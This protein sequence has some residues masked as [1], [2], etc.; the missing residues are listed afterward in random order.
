MAVDPNISLD[1]TGGGTG[2]S[3]PGQVPQ[4]NPLQTVGNIA[5]VQS[6][7]NAVR[8]FQAEMAAKQ[9]AGQILSAA[10]DLDTGIAALQRDPQTAAFAPQIA[11]SAA[12]T[13]ATMIAAAGQLQQQGHDAFTNMVKQLPAVIQD[14]SQWGPLVDSS[15]K[16]ASPAIRDSLKQSFD[17]LHQGLTDGLSDDPTEAANQKVQRL[18]GWAVANGAGDAIPQ[19][20]GKYVPTQVGNRIVPVWQAP[21]QGAPGGAPGALGQGPG[22]V[23]VGISPQITNQEGV[24]FGGTPGGGGGSASAGQNKLAL[25]APAQTAAAAPRATTAA[26]VKPT[27]V[28]P[29]AK[30]VGAAS[31]FDGA[32]LFD[33]STPMV[34][35]RAGVSTIAGNPAGLE[36]ENAKNLMDQFSKDGNLAYKNAIVTKGQL[37]EVNNNLDTM[38]RGGGLMVP[39]TAADFRTSLGKLITTFANITGTQPGVDPMKVAAAEDLNKLTQRMGI[40]YLQTQLGSQREAA[41]T[42]R[43]ITDKAIPGINNSLMGGKVLTSMIGALNDRSIDQYNWQTEWAAR[44]HGDLRGA[45]QAFS[46]AHPA[47]Q[48]INKALANLGMTQR[49]FASKAALQDALNRGL[50]TP[51]QAEVIRR[52]KGSIPDNLPATPSGQ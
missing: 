4:F 24:A 27:Q 44:N 32:P 5:E 31:A 22:S 46:Q 25:P 21:P 26:P 45:D 34:A 20:L 39:G 52:N 2:M 23:E 28:Q 49:G 50:L 1:V 42:I 9:R 37:A 19:I 29:V 18:T 8:L 36:G 14:E 11:A 51:E 15:L 43:N 41:E 17:R 3:Q 38:A 7:L 30:P 48:Y 13:R 33:A 10:P 6:R 47:E 12:S 16:L 35:P 40:N